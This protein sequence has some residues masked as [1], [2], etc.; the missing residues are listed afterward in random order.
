MLT[1]GVLFSIE[2]TAVYFAVRNYWRGFF[3]AV[4]SSVM[5]KSFRLILHP[6]DEVT[7]YVQVQIANVT[8]VVYFGFVNLAVSLLWYDKL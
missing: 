8:T 3:A 7:S 5:V 6:H 1:A 4:I 2:V